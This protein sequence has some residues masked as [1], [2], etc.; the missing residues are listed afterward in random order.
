MPFYFFTNI[1]YPVQSKNEQFE[2]NVQQL[3]TSC[4]YQTE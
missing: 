2:W 3:D 1:C 4:E